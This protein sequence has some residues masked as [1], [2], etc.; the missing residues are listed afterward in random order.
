MQIDSISGDAGESGVQYL[1]CCITRKSLKEVGGYLV[2]WAEIILTF[3]WGIFLPMLL[4]YW[5]TVWIFFHASFFFQVL[6]TY[7]NCIVEKMYSTNFHSVKVKSDYIHLLHM[8]WK[9]AQFV[10]AKWL[11]LLIRRHLRG[12]IPQFHQWQLVLSTN[13]RLHKICFKKKNISRHLSENTK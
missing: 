6:L 1:V 13:V 9:L 10:V 4:L 7:K 3:I 5:C 2:S 12:M 8:E 11:L